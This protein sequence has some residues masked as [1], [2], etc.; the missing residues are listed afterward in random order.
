MFGLVFFFFL[1]VAVRGPL[2]LKSQSLLTNG[3]RDLCSMSLPSHT[4]SQ[5]HRSSED[6]PKAN[7]KIQ[8]IRTHKSDIDC[9]NCL[10]IFLCWAAEDWT[11][12][13]GSYSLRKLR[14]ILKESTRKV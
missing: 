4:G 6:T 2:T 10:L 7:S 3:V 13:L 12:R 5:L 14:E 8:R 9:L 1:V 11:V